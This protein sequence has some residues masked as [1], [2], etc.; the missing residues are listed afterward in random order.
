[1]LHFK[2][3]PPTLNPETWGEFLSKTNLILTAEEGVIS[4]H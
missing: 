1:M 3:V 4:S 2:D